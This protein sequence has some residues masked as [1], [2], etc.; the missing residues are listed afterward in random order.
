M[1]GALDIKQSFRFKFSL[2]LKFMFLA[3]KQYC[4]DKEVAEFH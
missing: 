1:I 2:V 4:L 3:T